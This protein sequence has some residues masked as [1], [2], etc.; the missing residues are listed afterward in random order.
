M[1]DLP[2]VHPRVM[3]VQKARNDLSGAALDIQARYE[4][5][6]AEY[7]AILTELM[8]SALKYA[9]RAERHPDEPDRPTGIE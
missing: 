7:L 1:E 4:L 6:T 2:K 9:L 3:V 5:T 8:Q